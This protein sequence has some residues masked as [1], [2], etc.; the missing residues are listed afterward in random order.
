[1]VLL[2]LMLTWEA[3]F[4]SSVRS[5]SQD[6][7]TSQK[8]SRCAGVSTESS[9][10]ANV[11]KNFVVGKCFF[12]LSK[13]EFT[14]YHSFRKNLPPVG[15][16]LTSKTPDV[17]AT[18]SVGEEKIGVLLLNLGGPETLDDV[19]PFLYNLFADPVILLSL[20][21]CCVTVRVF[22]VITTVLEFIY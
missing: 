11:V 7:S 9:S 4:G 5:L 20:S 3:D 12:A 8:V 1:M 14:S 18:P 16:L 13:E 15:A 21:V 17:P 10:N 2:R 19:Q 6:I 22:V